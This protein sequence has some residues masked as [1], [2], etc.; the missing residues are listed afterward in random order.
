MSQ[1]V[2]LRQ[3]FADLHDPRRE[4]G[5]YHDLWDILG[6]TICAVIAGADSWVDV[7]EYGHCKLAWLKTFLALPNGI[8][9]HDT[10]G[11]VFRLINPAAFQQCFQHWVNA[12]VEATAGRVIAIDGK[13]ARRSCDRASGQGPLHL[14]SAWAAENHLTLGQLAVDGKS[15]EITAIPE[16]LKLIDVTGAIVTIDAMGCQKHI[17]A[18]IRAGGGDYVLALKD[19]QPTLHADVRQLFLDGLANDFADLKHHSCETVDE[20]HGRVEQ[21]YY[22]IVAVPAELA[23]K[24][25]EWPDWRSVG[26][27]YSERTVGD[28]EPSSE[29]RYFINSLPPKVKTFAR[30]VRGHWGIE[31]SLHWVLDV[32]FREDES[33]V[34]KDHAPEN[35]ALVRR[36]AA[37]LLKQEQTTKGGIACKRKQAGWDNAYLEQV[38]GAKLG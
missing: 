15:N 29:V 16:L 5:R 21:R 27:V 20:G 7:E 34:R 38:L 25:P 3:C 14:I 17:A 18:P 36:L 32:S 11:R 33:R 8:P 26:M 31:N 1:T 23:A 4:H 9:A 35:L 37:A 2:S 30:A 24:H 12:L 28:Q 22:H 19:N 10:L 6:L 13:T